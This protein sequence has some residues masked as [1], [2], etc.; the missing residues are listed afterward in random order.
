MVTKQPCRYS[1]RLAFEQHLG[2]VSPQAVDQSLPGARTHLWIALVA[3]LYSVSG[4]RPDPS[5]TWP[6]RI[7]EPDRSMAGG[8]RWASSVHQPPV[9]HVGA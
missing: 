7:E 8:P 3:D 9:S 2:G 1:H 4:H 6:R 5:V